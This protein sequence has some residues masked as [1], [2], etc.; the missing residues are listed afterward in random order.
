[1]K[2]RQP[3]RD[4]LSPNL[5]CQ[6]QYHISVVVKKYLKRPPRPGLEEGTRTKDLAFTLIGSVEHATIL[7]L[8]VFVREN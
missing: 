6:L 5:D 3:D 8:T 7:N 2:E 1:M 4:N